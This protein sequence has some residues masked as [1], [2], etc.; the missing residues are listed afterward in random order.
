M[1]YDSWNVGNVYYKN[2]PPGTFQYYETI[3]YTLIFTVGGMSYETVKTFLIIHQLC[4][5]KPFFATVN[6]HDWIIRGMTYFE[7][8]CMSTTFTRTLHFSSLQPLNFNKYLK[9]ILSR[10]CQMKKKKRKMGNHYQLTELQ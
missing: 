5:I 2:G 4:Y 1:H 3:F 10:I 9:G 7:R 6:K 8:F